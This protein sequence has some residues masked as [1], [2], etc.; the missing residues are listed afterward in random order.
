MRTGFRGADLWLASGLLGVLTLGVFGLLQ[1]SGPAS[2]IRRF[3]IAAA[4]DDLALVSELVIQDPNDPVVEE[5]R[6]TVRELARSGGSFQIGKVIDEG[7]RVRAMVL[8]SFRQG[9]AIT[10][11]VAVRPKGQP[12]WRIDAHATIANLYAVGIRRRPQGG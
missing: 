6:L 7:P 3:H 2:A 5:L 8:Y 11:W 9:T 12:K 1:Y 10:E 4:G